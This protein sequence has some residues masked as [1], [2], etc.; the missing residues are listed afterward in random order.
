LEKDP[1]LNDAPTARMKKFPLM[2]KLWTV[3]I[4]DAFAT[5][6]SKQMWIKACRR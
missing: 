5:D 3:E 4:L 6:L 2:C 1:Q